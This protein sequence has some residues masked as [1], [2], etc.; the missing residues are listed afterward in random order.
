M[1]SGY[2]KQVR[3]IS[4]RK[5]QLTKDLNEIREHGRI[6]RGKHSRQMDE[7]T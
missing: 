5:G 4:V 1:E 7:Q 2:V 3:K 6:L